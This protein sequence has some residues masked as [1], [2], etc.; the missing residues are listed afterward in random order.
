MNKTGG[1]KKKQ[2]M[3][4]AKHARLM[5]FVWT[6]EELELLLQVITKWQNNIV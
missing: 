2:N 5:S 4:D 3:M 1:R 6:D